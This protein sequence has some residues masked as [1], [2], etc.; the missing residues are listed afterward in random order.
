MFDL[1]FDFN[2]NFVFLLC[3][4]VSSL[5]ATLSFVPVCLLLVFVISFLIKTHHLFP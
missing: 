4:F 2:L 1:N 5:V 3:Y